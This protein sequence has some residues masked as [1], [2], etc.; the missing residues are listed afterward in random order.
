MAAE[1]FVNGNVYACCMFT[2]FVNYLIELTV[3][4]LLI[5]DECFCY[6]MPHMSFT[7]FVVLPSGHGR[8]VT[9]F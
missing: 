6:P 1:N 5:T 2:I 7:D 9:D 8:S 4:P 3:R